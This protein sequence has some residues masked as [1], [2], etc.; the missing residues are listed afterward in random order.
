ML[1]YRATP[2]C[3]AGIAPSELLFNRKIQTKLPQIE[4][5][6]TLPDTHP[7]I[8]EMGKQGKEKMKEHA[9]RRVRTQV[10][11]DWR[12]SSPSSEEKE[13]IQHEI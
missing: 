5:D 12:N 3:T 13:Q 1:N 10:S 6:T 7:N 9:D 2:H 11:Q 8:E 4:I